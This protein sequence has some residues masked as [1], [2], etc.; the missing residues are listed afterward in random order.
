MVDFTK[1]IDDEEE[2][3]T[4]DPEK[5]FA[6]LDRWASHTVLR[7]VQK[8]ALTE[9]FKRR[10]ERD[11]VLKLSTGAGKTTVA[12]VFLY[13]HMLEKQRPAVYLCTTTQLVKQTLS[14]ARRL[15]MQAVPY[16]SDT[17]HP[18]AESLSGRAITVCTYDKLF[19]AR[20]T[21]DRDDV[22]MT[23]CALVLDDAHAGMQRIRAKYTLRIEEK[24]IYERF[25]SI[26]KPRCSRY[27]PGQWS[28]IDMKDPSAN[29]EV[30]YWIWSDL[31]EEIRATLQEIATDK[32]YVFVWGYI[33]DDLRWCRCILS[34]RGIEIFPDIPLVHRARP[35]EEASC[36][37]FMSATLSDDSALVRE[38][39]CSEDAAVNPIVPSSDAGTGERMILAPSLIDPSLDRDWV[40][41]WCKWV[42]QHN[43]NVAVLTSSEKFA[44]DWEKVG[45]VVE[46]GDRVAATVDALCNET[47]RFVAFAQRYDGVDLPDNACRVLVLD[48]M[49]TG[50]GIGEEHD[51]S[52]PGRPGGALRRLAY[53]IEQGMGRAVRSEADYAVVILAGPELSNFLAKRDVVDL[54]GVATQAQLK[55]AEEL[56]KLAHTSGQKPQA[57]VSDMA[58]KCINRDAGWKKL[59]DKRVRQ[60][61]RTLDTKQERGPISQAASEHAAQEEAVRRDTLSAGKLIDRAINAYN[62][63]EKQEAWLLQRK[64]NY[65][66]DYDSAAALEIQKHAHRKNRHLCVPPGGIV[67]RPS[68]GSRVHSAASVIRWYGGFSSP[69]GAIARL[70]VIKNHLT[71]DAKPKKFEQALAEIAELFG[72]VGSRPEKEYARGPDDMWE[73]PEFSWVIEAKNERGI[74]P[75]GDGE[76]LLAAMEWFR[77]MYPERRG[78][79]IV[80]AKVLYAEF[81]AFFPE[82]TRVLTPDGLQLLTGNLDRFL[83]AL[84]TRPVAGW[85]AK[86]VTELLHRNTLL[87][88]QF[89][90]YTKRLRRKS[91]SSR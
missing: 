79:P 24:N 55:L 23:P 72:S 71:F 63:G 39:G 84:V 56:V 80:A 76:Q 38:L 88:D 8:E 48:G 26:L 42:T 9:L 15:G 30:P 21:F 7:P 81:N 90:C 40:M 32:P 25:L 60:K 82:G 51:R 18:G 78:V 66:F 61:T 75:K 17:P 53:R 50:E 28:G 44:R 43:I 35:Y 37:L 87:A 68:S 57:A 74:L 54:L 13:S 52:I 59:Y 4:K 27:H 89:S 85:T 1:F 83:R 49:P 29:M 73:W 5:L 16:P 2:F 58:V 22:M 47:L 3:D 77:E 45:A 41:G 36:R 69:N 11:I 19:N 46:L 34:G 70:E 67:A 6:S 64:A 12:L 65:V 62:S 31:L 91:G 33:R 10:N 14:E 86:E 20:T